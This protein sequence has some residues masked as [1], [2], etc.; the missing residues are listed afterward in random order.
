[1]G[2]TSRRHFKLGD[3]IRRLVWSG[4][5]Q[6]PRCSHLDQVQEVTPSADGCEDC[7]KIGDQWVHLR[8]CLVCG[9]VGCCDNSKNKHA[10]KHYHAT[11][12]PLIMSLEQGEDW[13]WC[14]ID[15]ALITA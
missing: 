1:M 4:K 7:L 13:M 15:Q 14:Y 8:L 9:H 2:Q 3:T 10:T 12:H 11:Q 6:E 5:I